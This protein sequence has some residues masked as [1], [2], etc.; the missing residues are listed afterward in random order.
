MD[1]V[2]RGLEGVFVYLDNV[3]VPSSDPNEQACHLCTLFV[4][5]QQDHLIVRLEKCSFGQPVLTF[6]GYLVNLARIKPLP[7][8]V[9]AV[10]FKIT[11]V[12]L[13]LKNSVDS[14]DWIPLSPTQK[15]WFQQLQSFTILFS[16]HPCALSVMLVNT[17]LAQPWNSRD[18]V[19]GGLYHSSHSTSLMLNQWRTHT[20]FSVPMFLPQIHYDSMYILSC[21]V[22]ISFTCRCSFLLPDFPWRRRPCDDH[23]PGL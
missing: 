16:K 14:W 2:V 17:A 6:L 3:L 21:N 10:Q 15:T 8:R 4:S 22:M 1:S 5:L 18:M 13:T 12:T 19:P 23:M 7:S 20:H 9:T 11:P